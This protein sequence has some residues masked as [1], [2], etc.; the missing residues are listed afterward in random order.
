LLLLKAQVVKVWDVERVT[1]TNT[2][3]GH[4]GPV[5]CVQFDDEKIISGSD[6]HV[7]SSL[8]LMSLPAR[9]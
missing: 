5:R 4:D 7:F 2:L 6:D 8:A 9:H 1:S 3:F